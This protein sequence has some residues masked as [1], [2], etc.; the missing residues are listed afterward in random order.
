MVL[1]RS[2]KGKVHYSNDGAHLLC[3]RQATG[4][5][6]AATRTDCRRCIKLAEINRGLRKGRKPKK[7]GTKFRQRLLMGGERRNGHGYRGEPQPF[8]SS[9]E[10]EDY[11]RRTARAARQAAQELARRWD[12]HYLL[13]YHH[14]NR[15]KPPEVDVTQAEW[16]QICTDELARR[17]VRTNGKRTLTQREAELLPEGSRIRRATGPKAPYPALEKVKGLWLGDRPSTHY[18]G[19]GTADWEVLR[20]GYNR[21]NGRKKR[22]YM[23]TM[24]TREGAEHNFGPYDSELAARDR[25]YDLMNRGASNGAGGRIYFVEGRY[26]VWVP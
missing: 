21:S 7:T 6:T 12:D 16:R 20:V 2:P 23:V 9:E 5:A 19:I 11:K 25:K 26:Y 8:A 17:G 10:Y 22:S 13:Q 1:L 3:D 4:D 15:T 14:H 18:G 24:K